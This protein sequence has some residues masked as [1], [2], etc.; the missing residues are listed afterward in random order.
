MSEVADSELP[1]DGEP[2]RLHIAGL[3]VGFIAGLPQLIFPMLAALFGARA[4]NNPIMIPII[5]GA[6]FAFSLFFRWLAW[7]RFTYTL[8]EHDI[9]IERGLLSRT[10][11]SI[12]Y[13]RI[14][15]VSVE[16]QFLARLM[17]LAE[18]K[19][20]SGGGEGED[21]KL[22]YVSVAQA[23]ALRESIRER[24]SG[25]VRATE[26]EPEVAAAERPPIFAM[27]TKRLITFGLYSFS[28]I[29]FAVLAGAAQ[30]VD[31]LLPFNFWDIGA[32]IGVAED[33]GVNIDTITH[34]GMA[35]RIIGAIVALIALLVVG[36]ASGILR[37]ALRDYGF[38]L[39]R[40]DRGL[41][42]RRG[43][44]TR[45]DVVMPVHRVQGA[46][47]QTG[48]IRKRRGWH[49]L[50]FVSLAQD[51]KKE[52]DYLAVPFGQLDEIWP[53]A[54]EA[55]LKSP[56]SD[57]PF[58]RGA[59]WAWMIWILP[60]VLALIGWTISAALALEL[61]FGVIARTYLLLIPAALLIWLNWRRYADAE[62]S[63]QLYVRRGWW[64]ERLNIVDQVKVQTV[65][66]AQGP[67][68]RRLGLAT[69]HFG[70]A[71][72]NL[73]MVAVPLAKARAIRD[74]VMHNV[75]AVDFSEINKAT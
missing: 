28:L 23:E 18:V 41:R 60:V 32:W 58:R 57:L 15:D 33:R 55:G 19:F 65:E 46:I 73:H 66:I 24:K 67:L 1:P 3:F 34:I 5:V 43:L 11:R 21:A 39:D 61:P 36:L 35:A 53:V 38:R 6:A 7:R 40:T 47:I 31:F 22:S 45:T 72:G 14:Q 20:E 9:R 62:D 59:G 75:A 12:P 50:K 64:R 30:Q 37:V 49:A 54:S 56:A 16:Q 10:V 26:A 29:I 48:P 17:G 70:I 8:G 51:S 27:D 44:F 68:S 71:G 74:A 4:G 2:Q 52:P 13:E 42:R 69:I 25:E 63:A